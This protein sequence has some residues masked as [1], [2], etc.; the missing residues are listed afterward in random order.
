M[1]KVILSIEGMSCSA[2]QN[3]LEKYLKKQPHIID[4]S[5]NLVLK[6]ALITY[7]EVLSINDL[8]QMVH[9]AGF[10]SLGIY[11][12]KKENKTKKNP[13]SLI[14][15]GLLAVLVL[16]I[17]MG[18]MVHLPV[19]PFLNMMTH[20]LNYALCLCVLAIIYLF[21]GFDILKNGFKNIILG[22]P[23]MDTLVTVG[24]LSSFFYSVYSTIMIIKGHTEFV[25][26]LYYES[27]SLVLYFVKLG[28]Y[29]DD[30]SKE[31]TK[32]AIKD[33]VK[34][35]P[36]KAL[37][38][39]GT[40]EKEI[41]IDMVHVGDILIC[42]PGMKVAV[43][44]VIVKGSSHINEAFI[45]GESV[46]E[47]KGVGE[48]VLAGSLNIDGYIE[49][50][51]LKIGKDSTI[52]EIV[53]LVVE[54]TNTKAPIARLADQVS[55][56]FVPTIIVIAILTFLSYLLLGYPFNLAITHFVTV[57]V[58]AC[59]CALGLATPLAIVV[60]E[61]L[62]AKNGILVKSSTILEN[63]HKI[64]TFVFDKTGTLTYGDLKIFKMFNYTKNTNE[65]ILSNIALIEKNSTHPIAKVFK[66]YESKNKVAVTDYIEL[67]G[68]GVKG[69]LNDSMYLIGNAKI[70]KEFNVPNYY[71]EDESILTKEGC[72]IIYVVK[73]NKVI[74]L[75]GIKDIIRSE[76]PYVIDTLKKMGKEVIMLTGDN[77]STAR[78][79]AS[80]L[81]IDK[82]TAN[83]MPKDKSSV[84]KKLL[85]ENKKVMMIGDGINDAPS[86]ALASIG[87]S[88]KSGTD[89]AG[90]E[91]SVILMNNNL[92]S[93]LNLYTISEKTI[94]NIKQN[95]FW[96]F[97]YNMC[98][99][100]VAMGLFT[101]F[102]LNMNPMLAS[103]A[104]TLS[105]LTVI[106]N[107]L[108]LKKIKLKR[109]E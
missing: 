67:P 39:E 64:D 25:E 37:V 48:A 93:I 59:P 57:L 40:K 10:K 96:A 23:N 87:V 103:I 26:S 63:A 102:G 106:L 18:H 101:K 94:K 42:K 90:N 83:V 82:V 88:L 97:F 107:A 49:Y 34:I 60:S 3:S 65:K 95:L 45:T 4:A 46:P 27:A 80:S 24:V 14:V 74:A 53:K 52:S 29:I 99:L 58:V 108:R 68:L 92:K 50:K 33:L 36:E 7:E 69:F 9:A 17:S 76:S 75:I 55:S 21:Y 71:Q 105:S 32:D 5:V 13:L 56:V 44:G 22:H 6:Q 84:I 98:M 11:N 77:E 100:P 70:L 79:I 1:K 72:S 91:A 8:N 86:L 47:K 31:K 19:I 28:R 62:C 15:F 12:A 85:N 61:G 30:F 54:S 66:A 81:K 16:Y 20:P 2:C 89:I 104:M 51:A 109:D 35:T 43:D 78:V 73:D 41:T 38:K